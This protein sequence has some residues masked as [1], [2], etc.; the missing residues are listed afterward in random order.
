[1]NKSS[2][3]IDQN[4]ELEQRCTL[5]R[6]ELEQLGRENAIL[7]HKLADIESSTLES[8]VKSCEIEIDKKYTQQTDDLTNLPT[9]CILSDRINQSMMQVRSN[10]KRGRSWDWCALIIFD[11][12]NLE[13]VRSAIGQKL[14]DQLIFS[15]SGRAV[16]SCSDIDTVARLSEGQFA[17][18]KEKISDR[19]ELINFCSD[20]MESLQLPIQAGR[21]DISFSLR[22]G[23]ALFPEDAESTEQ[24]YEKAE[25]AM[26]QAPPGMADSFIFYGDD[27]NSDAAKQI[28][29]SKDLSNAVSNNEFMLLYQPKINLESA[30]IAGMEA[31]IRWNHPERGIL[32]PFFFIDMLEQNPILMRRVGLWTILTAVQQI[33][34]WLDSGVERDFICSVNL[35]VDQ[36][37]DPLLPEQIKM[38]LTKVGVDPKY[39]EMELVE[40]QQI[41]NIENDI[42]SIQKL[43]EIGIRISIDDFGTGYSSLSYLL[44]VNAD[45][46]KIDKCFIDS[47]D[48]NNLA[49]QSSKRDDA[50]FLIE[51]ILSIGKKMKMTVVAEGVEVVEQMEWL[52][53]RDCDEI[54]GY[55]FSRPVA[56]EDLAEKWF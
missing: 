1:M 6:S 40:S 35:T 4:R 46:L 26:R 37:R 14:L 30:E 49:I 10:V 27:L 19:G 36:L 23:V 56:P 8:M 53:E 55:Y 3:T 16:H 15:F 2:N 18:F 32:A 21:F 52:K 43:K 42:L 29:L 9:G 33:R 45:T 28:E 11:L 41:D 12:T 7:K 17:I 50:S 48:T 5:L 54:Q 31:L 20:L 38:I 47:L 22:A 44:N 13:E 24:L 34:K 25:I 39:L 51:T